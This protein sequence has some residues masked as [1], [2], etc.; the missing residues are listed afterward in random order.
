MENSTAGKG[1]K[2][3]VFKVVFGARCPRCG[4][5]KLFKDPNPYNLKNYDQMNRYCSHC[6]MDFENETGFYYGAMYVS[7]ALSVAISVVNFIWTVL[8]FGFGRIWIFITINAIVLV[9]LWPFIFRISRVLY[10]WMM[11][12]L[13]KGEGAKPDEA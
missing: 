2:R 4:Q 9:L 1:S 7:Y 13:F 10:L 6:N 12:L 8:A 11:D 5:G 3:S